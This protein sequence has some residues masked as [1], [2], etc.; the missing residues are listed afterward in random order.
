ME[1]WPEIEILCRTITPRLL[2]IVNYLASVLQV[3]IGVKPAPAW[4][5]K[6]ST[7]T[8]GKITINYARTLVEG[9]F[10]IY[11]SG[12]L[13][14]TGISKPEP[15]VFKHQEQIMLFPA[16]AGFD[17]PFDLLSAAF[18][19]LSRYEEY[20]P[21]E[22][23]EHDRFEADQS[24]AFHH[25]FLDEPVVDQWV[26]MLKAALT[27]KFP[28]LRFPEREFRFEST[29]DIDSPW[30]YLH[31][32]WLRMTA[33]LIKHILLFHFSEVRL[34]LAVL[35]GKQRDPFDTYDY[36]R[37]REQV[38][39]FHSIFFLLTGNKSQYDT[40]YAL[41]TRPFRELVHYLKSVDN[42]GIH[43]SYRSNQDAELLISEF[44]EFFRIVGKYPEIS[45]QHFL[46]L[47]FPDTYRHLTVMGIKKD[48]SMGYVSYTGFRA[49]TSQSFKFYDLKA[50]H[51]TG[52]LLHPFQV[53]DVTLQQY[54]G[55]NPEEALN[56]ID[57]L[58]K[59]VKKVNGTFT[60]LWHNESLS[61][62]GI[63]KGWRIVFEKMIEMSIMNYE[64]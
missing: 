33:G 17:L 32:G 14:E 63:W 50:E 47:K 18:F 22:P 52:L 6:N 35:W 15:G 27:K 7:G 58:V 12:L 53:M 56:T 26:E 38:H 10:N 19:L 55:L 3:G 36:I 48:Y 34:R 1:S 25:N 20:L 21:F 51:E 39:A 61:D 40:N 57:R 29:I 41:K 43:P 23:D 31:K 13:G 45:R 8:G 59:K 44:E 24:L 5:I 28:G 2:Y 11:P 62:T 49:G 9:V 64:L 60:S 54:L 30:A 16:P 46:I 37:K 4:E 42:L